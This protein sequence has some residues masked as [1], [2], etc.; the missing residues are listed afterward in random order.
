MKSE[1]IILLLTDWLLVETLD[2]QKGS[3]YRS[4]LKSE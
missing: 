4:R 1:I 3:V 2:G